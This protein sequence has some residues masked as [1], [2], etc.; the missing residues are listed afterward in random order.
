MIEATP[1]IE[2]L[3]AYRKKLVAAGHVSKAA[4]VAHCIAIVRRLSK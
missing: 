1:L 2:A 4:A 3:A